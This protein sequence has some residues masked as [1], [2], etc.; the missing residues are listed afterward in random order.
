[1]RIQ[2][3]SHFEELVPY[4]DPWD[5]LSA[6]VPFRSWIWMSTWWRHYGPGRRLF[7]LGVF[8]RDDALVG[9]APWYLQHRGPWGQ[10][11]EFLGS[12]EVCSD[13][14]SI[15][16]QPP[17]AEAVTAA[18]AAWL[19]RYGKEEAGP[20]LVKLSG[21]AADDLA[22][23]RLAAHLAERG[24][25]IHRRAGPNC[26]R[27]RLPDS[28]DAYEALLSKSH[29]KQ[30]RRLLRT[31]EG[32]GRAVLH[33]VTEPEEL[34]R[35]MEILTDLHQRRR[36]S[37]AEPGR[38]ASPRF[39]A[40]HG[41]VAGP[42]LESGRLRLHWL[43]RSGRP[44]AAEYHLAGGAVIY[45]YQA[46]VDPDALEHEPGSLITLAVL[47]RAMDEGY[48][49]FDFLRGD[50]P[51]KAHWRAE[52]SASVELRLVAPRPLARL[53]HGLWLAGSGVKRWATAGR[54]SMNEVSR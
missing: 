8:D 15:L 13:Y 54:R 53:R 4:R 27:L 21:V 22:T 6:D 40:F 17:L 42:L 18:L 23:G 44:I 5:R 47:R 34:P 48:R 46:G 9:I 37:L 2:R 36:L 16:C 50:E 41:A 52:P 14:L 31:L 35:A 43:E 32:P 7:V 38:F 19:D 25:T 45:A 29:R 51:Y 1:M 28:W 10:V 24:S 3:F 12:G 26:W 39:T 33:T 20:D 11:A 49:Q 30:V